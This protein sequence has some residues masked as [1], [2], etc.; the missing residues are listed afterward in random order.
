MIRQ[1]VE[2]YKLWP[3][4]HIS[5]KPRRTAI[6]KA[7]KQIVE[8]A[9]IEGI[10]EVCIMEDDVFFPSND[11]YDYFLKNKPDV[12]DLYL[13]GITRGDIKD[14]NEVKRYTGQFCYFI[15]ERYYTTF[16]DTDENLD[17]DGGQSGRGQFVVCN[18]MACFC[19]PG[20]SENCNGVMDYSHLLVGKNI[21]GFGEVSSKTRAKEFSE[22]A[23]SLK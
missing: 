8:W 15:H 17:I 6:S 14:N 9:L 21:Y 19:Y 11:G 10:E 16:L 12:Y 3:S 23:K 20:W 1:S 18:P 4:I 22:L 2:N 13:A 5:N 7:H